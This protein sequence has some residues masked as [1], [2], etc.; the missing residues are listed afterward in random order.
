MP[1]KDPALKKAHGAAYHAAN[2]ER[3]HARQ[4]AYRESH[5]EELRAANV[6]YYWANRTEKLRKDAAYAAAH[7]PQIKAYKLRYDSLH[8]AFV[9]AARAGGCVDCG[10]K[11]LSVLHSDHVR[12]KK[13]D[14]VG[15]MVRR[16]VPLEI[17]FAELDKCE[18]RCA[19]CHML[20]TRDRRRVA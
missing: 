16:H 19:N 13:L 3:I 11:N 8:M 10:N 18:T 17:L 12:G 9:D 15:V 7:K 5:K 1:Y 20:A 14:D 4:A 6:R 2:R